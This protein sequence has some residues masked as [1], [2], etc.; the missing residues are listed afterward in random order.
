VKKRIVAIPAV[1]KDGH[2]T[3][4]TRC[5]RGSSFIIF[6]QSCGCCASLVPTGNSRWNKMFAVANVAFILHDFVGLAVFS[7][8][9]AQAMFKEWSFLVRMVQFIL[10]WRHLDQRERS[11]GVREISPFGRDDTEGWSR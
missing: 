8:F 1:I 6:C 11:H 10:L 5:I 7:T 9:H 4:T 2:N 3:A